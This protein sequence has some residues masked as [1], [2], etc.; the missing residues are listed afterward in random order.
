MYI[1]TMDKLKEEKEDYEEKIRKNQSTANKIREDYFREL[2]GNEKYETSKKY[3]ELF[4]D[5]INSTKSMNKL[6]YELAEVLDVSMRN[7]RSS[8]T[9]V[10]I[11]F[12]DKPL[13]LYP[14]GFGTYEWGRTYK[15]SDIHYKQIIKECGD[16]ILDYVW[17]GNKYEMLKVFNEELKKWIDIEHV[18]HHNSNIKIDVPVP[19][20]TGIVYINE[21]TGRFL[22]I[23]TRISGRW[24]YNQG[25]ELSTS[26]YGSSDIFKL[27][28]KEEMTPRNIF[29]FSYIYDD[30]IEILPKDKLM[31]MK[32][33]NYI[34]AKILNRIK[35][36]ILPFITSEQI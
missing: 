12:N 18:K 36:R 2:I 34:N 20:E 4:V 26:R 16:K 19:N 3:L 6:E 8:S 25:I 22:D 7:I 24:N 17:K 11:K 9:Q 30:V 13:R 33:N 23:N 10:G 31:K 1:K 28:K 35:E 21:K 32:S 27:Y 14:A 5:V 29:I 15:I